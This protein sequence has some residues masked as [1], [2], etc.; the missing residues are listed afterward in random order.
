MSIQTDSKPPGSTLVVTA[1]CRDT[2]GLVEPPKGSLVSVDRV[3]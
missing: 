1:L 3:A 2:L